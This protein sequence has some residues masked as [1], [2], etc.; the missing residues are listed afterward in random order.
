MFLA[1]KMLPEVR[2][3]HFIAMCDDTGLFQHAL[4]T[5]ADRAHGYCIDDNARA[6]LLACALGA[7]A[8][9]TV[10]APLAASFAAFV[11]HAWNPALGRFRNFMGFDRRWLEEAGSEDSHARTLWALGVSARDDAD[12]PRRRWAAALFEEALPI[13]GVFTSPRA[14][15]FTLLGLAAFMQTERATIK[16][17][18][19]QKALAD[20]LMAVLQA[21][22]T[23]DW[24]WF[25]EGLSYDNARLPQAL[26]VTGEALHVPAYIEAGLK[27]LRWLVARQTSPAGYFRPVGTEG[28]KDIRKPPEKFDQ[29]P[30]EAA[31]TISA[32]LAAARLREGAGWS[33][34]A[35]RAFSWFRG[36]N[37]LLVALADEVTGG[38]RDG[39]HPDRANENQGA[40]SVLSYLLG[41]CEMRAMAETSEAQTRIALRITN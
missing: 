10:P 39:L 29:Q 24:V 25:E 40:E 23:Q 2:L 22:E 4:Y 17:G 30:V 8:G 36:K 16:A 7:G 15:A 28:F 14:W 11:Q 32:C 31:A 13:A 12:V 3:G 34:E 19:L 1:G 37:D 21:V 27:T 35:E 33:E 5:V 18:M 20:Q 9:E 6:I 26:L 41:L 38:C